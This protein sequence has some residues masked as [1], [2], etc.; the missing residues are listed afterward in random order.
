[1][2]WPLTSKNGYADAREG[3][4]KKLACER[5]TELAVRRCNSMPT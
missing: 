5:T 3:V 2:S 1:M 4:L